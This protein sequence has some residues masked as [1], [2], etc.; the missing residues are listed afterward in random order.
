MT[1]LLVAADGHALVGKA[2]ECMCTRR[3]GM[4]QDK[5]VIFT[6]DLGMEGG[7]RWPIN[8]NS[9]GWIATDAENLMVWSKRIDLFIL[10]GIG[11]HFERG[12]IGL[13]GKLAIFAQSRC[14]LGAKLLLKVWLCHV[15]GW[16]IWHLHW[17]NGWLEVAY[18]W[19]RHAFYA[20]WSISRI[21]NLRAL[22]VSCGHRRS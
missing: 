2:V 1:E 5:L 17:E 11:A 22:G 10:I 21:D 18:W 12:T 19:T 8:H 16:D 6:D 15:D 4:N 7:N 13:I 3:M 9:V 14:T 20:L